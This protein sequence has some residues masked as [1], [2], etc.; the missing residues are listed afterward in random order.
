LIKKAQKQDRVSQFRL[1]EK[2][3]PKMLSVVRC[4]IK[5]LQH[6][7]DVLQK[8]FCKAF[9]NMKSYQFKGSFEGWLRRIVVT[10]SIDF[11][12]QKKNMMIQTDDFSY[13][14]TAENPLDE[15]KDISH[16]QVAIDK[17]PE[18]YKTVFCLYVLEEY[19]HKDIAE[20]LNIDVGTSKSQLYKARKML[21]AQL[22]NHQLKSSQ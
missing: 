10:S 8:A 9:L 13:Y 21:K 16:I 18:G 3:S 22:Q 6:A 5:D 11:L 20:M 17:L 7:E 4:Y 2:Y 12:R 1:Y 15:V 19:K 14:E